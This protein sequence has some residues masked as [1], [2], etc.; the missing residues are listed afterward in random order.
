MRTKYCQSIHR[1]FQHYRTNLIELM[2]IITQHFSF[3][4]PFKMGRVLTAAI[5][6]QVVDRMTLNAPTAH[7]SKADAATNR[8]STFF[9]R[10]V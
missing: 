8:L 5:E 7:N 1:R 9:S 4:S 2:Q 6:I 3:N 10:H